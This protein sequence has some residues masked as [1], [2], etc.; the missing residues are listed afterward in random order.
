MNIAKWKEFS[1]AVDEY[2]KKIE[3]EFKQQI[4][5]MKQKETFFK[6]YDYLEWMVLSENTLLQY[7]DKT[8][9]NFWEWQANKLKLK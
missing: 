1:D 7:V 4:E 8:E 6:K 9:V 5:E 3:K 2:N